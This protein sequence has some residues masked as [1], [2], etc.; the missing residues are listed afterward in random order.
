ML[1]SKFQQWNLSRMTEIITRS[2]DARALAQ[3]L[4]KFFEFQLQCRLPQIDK[5]KPSSFSIKIELF[6]QTHRPGDLVPELVI[7]DSP[8]REEA[9]V[10]ELL[11]LN[12]IVLGYPKFRIHAKDD[13]QWNLA[14]NILNKAD[15]PVMLPTSTIRKINFLALPDHQQR[16][17]KALTKIWNS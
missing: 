4:W 7:R 1:P 5:D 17:C 16:F 10:H 2:A 8:R 6:L 14:A 9:L 15:H 11:H 13:G 3:R 12:L